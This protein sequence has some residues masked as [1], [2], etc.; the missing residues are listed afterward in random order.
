MLGTEEGD[1]PRRRCPAW[2]REHMLAVDGGGTGDN[3]IGCGADVVDAGAR[4]A[5]AGV[6]GQ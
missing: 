5:G 2:R 4:S 1:G 6:G 3:D